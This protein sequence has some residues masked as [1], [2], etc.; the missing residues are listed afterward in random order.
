ML[1]QVSGLRDRETDPFRKTVGIYASFGDTGNDKDSDWGVSNAVQLVTR[2]AAF[3][4]G[5]LW[6]IRQ[7]W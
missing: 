6:K 5:R 3:S 4:G 7:Q 2:E 1:W